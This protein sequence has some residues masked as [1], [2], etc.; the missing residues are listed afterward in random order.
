MSNGCTAPVD[1]L[2]PSLH[3]WVSGVGGRW[4][5]AAGGRDWVGTTGGLRQFLAIVHCTVTTL[6]RGS[7][8]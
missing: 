3:W 1:L 5:V 2:C 4:R 8:G 6:V 7:A